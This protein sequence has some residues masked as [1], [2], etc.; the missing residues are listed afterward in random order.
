MDKSLVPTLIGGKD[1]VHNLKQIYDDKLLHYWCNCT[2]DINMPGY[3]S[4]ACPDCGVLPHLAR[5]VYTDYWMEG[6]GANEYVVTYNG[7]TG[8]ML[9]WL[10][11]YEW[12]KDL[13]LLTNNNAEKIKPL[14]HRY[15]KA[16]AEDLACDL[17][18]PV[19]YG[20]DTDPDGD[21][22]LVY[23]SLGEMQK[24]SSDAHDLVLDKTGAGI[25][26]I[27]NNLYRTVETWLKIAVGPIDHSGIVRKLRSY[28]SQ[29]ERPPYGREI[30]GEVEL[31]RSAALAI[32]RLAAELDLMKRSQCIETPLGN[33]I[34]RPSC[35]PAYPGVWIDLSRPGVDQSKPIALVEFTQTES[36][37]PAGEG[38]IITRVWGRNEDEYSDRIVHAGIDQFFD[39]VEE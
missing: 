17:S 24:I 19:F 5:L 12:L 29:H 31:E 36:D 21:E 11:D 34:A 20:E 33:L 39:G 26:V 7:D 25:T 38:H 1:M 32:E 9:G 6:R 13:G 8:L 16:A 28:A 23:L 4:S 14:F 37:L 2:G 35:D 18:F 3:P 30:D 10:F 27:G 22:I 15:V